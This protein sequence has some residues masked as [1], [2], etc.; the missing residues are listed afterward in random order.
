LLDEQV[1]VHALSL[2]HAH[3]HFAADDTW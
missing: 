1:V 2:A 3:K